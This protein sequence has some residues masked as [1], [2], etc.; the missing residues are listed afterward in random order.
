MIL[1]RSNV[2]YS[3]H[4]VH[5]MP[6]LTQSQATNFE[7]RFGRG[8]LPRIRRLLTTL[9]V[10]LI[11]LGLLPGLLKVLYIMNGKQGDHSC[12]C[13]GSVSLSVLFVELLLMDSDF[14]AGSGKSVLWWVIQMILVDIGYICT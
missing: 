13:T 2:G 5:R 7:K 3:R 8:F 9:S 11:T 14:L 4:G 10:M 6:R 1:T 12:G